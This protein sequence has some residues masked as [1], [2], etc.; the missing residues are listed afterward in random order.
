M[1]CVKLVRGVT[2]CWR[3]IGSLLLTPVLFIRAV[4]SKL[5]MC[6]DVLQG[7][8]PREVMKPGASQAQGTGAQSRMLAVYPVAAR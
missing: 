4:L 6:P 7:D 5:S 8:L 2:K 3:E 1:T